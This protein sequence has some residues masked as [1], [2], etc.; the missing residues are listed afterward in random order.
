[1]GAGMTAAASYLAAAMRDARA[2]ELRHLFGSKAEAGLFDDVGR[3]RAVI[4]DRASVGNLYVT[5]NRPV[6]SK[7][8]ANTMGR[9]GLHDEDIERIV[10]LPF[11]FDPVRPTG[12]SSTARELA[13]A[14][15]Q[16]DRFGAAQ[17][18]LGWPMPALGVS[19]NGAHAIYRCML[20]AGPH[21]R[22]ALRIPYTAFKN[23]FSTESVLFDS[24]VYNASRIWRLYGT[25]NRK[26]IPT[27]ERPHRRAE[28]VIPHTWAAVSPEQ[29]F[30][31]EPSS[32]RASDR[33]IRRRSAR[34]THRFKAAAIIRLSM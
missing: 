11:D 33:A 30:R 5:L 23:D 1:M 15:V 34:S 29:V 31:L 4:S 6:P 14:V 9:R 19:G 16:R 20:R 8:A 3:L 13:M 25:I 12:T 18:A 24:T 32:T 26:G 28:I 22:D 21:T 10:R 17:Y 7:R 2:I 27:D